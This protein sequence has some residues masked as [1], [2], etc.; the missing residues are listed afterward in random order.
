M[1]RLPE[2]DVALFLRRLKY[3]AVALLIGW[4]VWLLAPI[5]TPFVLALALAWL[6]DP[7]VDRI[8]ATGRSRNTG[9]VLVFVAM[10]LLITGLLPVLV[11]LIE[12]QIITLLS[13]LPHAQACMLPFI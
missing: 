1:S 3:V 5:L 7:L 11:P 2:A 13:S 10:V 6:G 9:V 4:V 12:R 8:E